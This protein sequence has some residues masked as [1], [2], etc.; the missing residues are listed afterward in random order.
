MQQDARTAET[1]GT[2]SVNRI[3]CACGH[4][5]APNYDF[6][7]CLVKSIVGP[8][9]KKECKRVKGSAAVTTQMQALADFSHM[10]KKGDS[11]PL[12]VEEDQ[13][14]EGGCFWLAKIDD[15]PERL[16][17]SITFGGQVFQEGWIVAKARYYSFLQERGPAAARVRLEVIE[18]P[19]ETGG[20]REAH[21][22]EGVEE[23]TGVV[24]TKHHGE[25]AHRSG[26]VRSQEKRF[27]AC[28]LCFGGAGGVWLTGAS[29]FATLLYSRS[30][31]Q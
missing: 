21:E 6:Q 31:T 29:I 25:S 1:L 23:R 4:C 14:G 10:V 20:A 3:H 26:A 9:T 15:H 16:E 13:E 11:W 8:S 12:R 24:A 27:F 30:L 18:S 22:R 2:L 7:N 19:R 17:E 28:M 5:K